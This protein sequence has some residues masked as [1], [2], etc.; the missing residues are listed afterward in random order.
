MEQRD[1]MENNEIHQ[2]EV[3]LKEFFP[4]PRAFRPFAIFD[5]RLDCIRVLARD[6]SVT[7]TRINERLTL[8]EDN[9]PEPGLKQYIGFTIKGPK[10]FCLTH[11]LP[12]TGPV[13][14]TDILDQIVRAYPDMLVQLVVNA[15]AR[16]ILQELSSDTVELPLAA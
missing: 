6:C 8:L 16:P 4:Q 7:E 2:I 14:L 11:G 12:G 3:Q 5:E 9:Y 1:M 13:S 10:H 15:V